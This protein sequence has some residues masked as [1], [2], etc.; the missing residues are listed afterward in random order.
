[1]S[2]ENAE[3]LY[4]IPPRGLVGQLPCTLRLYQSFSKGIQLLGSFRL[5]D[6]YPLGARYDVA[7]VTQ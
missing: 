7:K 5:V 4:R 3:K 1:M 6:I 2:F